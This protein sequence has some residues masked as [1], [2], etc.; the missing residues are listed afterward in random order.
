MVIIYNRSHIDGRLAA[1]ITKRRFPDADLYRMETSSDLPFHGLKDHEVILIDILPEPA[2]QLE[3]WAERVQRVTWLHHRFAPFDKV[4]DNVTQ[5]HAPHQGVSETAWR[6]YFPDVAIPQVVALVSA[7]AAFRRDEDP[8]IIP[9]QYGLRSK[10]THPGSPVWAEL[11]PA[12]D[13]DPQARIRAERSLALIALHGDIVMDYVL[14]ESQELC[15]RCAFETVIDGYRCLALNAPRTTRLV[16]EP[17]YDAERHDVMAGF[18]R[19]GVGVW[20]V[21]LFAEKPGVDC[22]QI[23]RQRGGY[24]HPQSAGFSCIRL[25]WQNDGTYHGI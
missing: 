17:A 18:Y 9:V 7:Y 11:L 5:V 15:R 24:G 12:N 23:A 19:N 16:F 21:R 20:Q 10:P 13:T 2:S 22:F 1:E 14:K 8:R 25:P 6:L 3:P 4:P